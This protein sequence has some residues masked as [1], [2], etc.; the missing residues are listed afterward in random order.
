MKTKKILLGL[1]LALSFMG[2][3]SSYLNSPKKNSLETSK[4]TFLP[5]QNPPLET[6]KNEPTIMLQARLA[7]VLKKDKDDC[8]RVNGDL[9]IWPYGSTL[10]DE[11]IYDKEANILAE[12]G[13]NVIFGG[14]GVSSEEDSVEEIKKISDQLPNIQCSDP[15]FFVN[16][17]M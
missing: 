4:R 1:T 9:I 6:Q 11:L 8:I 15:Y 16:S 5:T 2:C 7:G 13:K 17:V 12:I 3:D 10:K 14:G